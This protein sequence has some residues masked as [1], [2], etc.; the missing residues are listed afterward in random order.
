MTPWS[1]RSQMLRPISLLGNIIQFLQ[2][3]LCNKHN[4]DCQV[5]KLLSLGL[6]HVGYY[7]LALLTFVDF[8]QKC[9][10]SFPGWGLKSFFE[11]DHLYILYTHWKRDDLAAHQRCHIES[12]PHKLIQKVWHLYKIFLQSAILDIPSI[13]CWK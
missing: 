7:F 12:I 6:P 8:D 11:N 5:Q 10:T 4:L 9:I 3:D 13:Q 1:K 2:L